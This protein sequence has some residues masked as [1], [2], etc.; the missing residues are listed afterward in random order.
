MLA[1][2]LTPF[3]HLFLYLAVCNKSGDLFDSGQ[4]VFVF[5]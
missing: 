2:E 3:T 4:F 1:Q 5:S